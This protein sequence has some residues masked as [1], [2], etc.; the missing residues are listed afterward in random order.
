MVTFGH[1]VNYDISDSC[2]KNGECFKTFFEPDSTSGTPLQSFL[3]FYLLVIYL[4]QTHHF[5]Y[6]KLGSV[7]VMFGVF[8]VLRITV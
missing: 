6:F 3:G 4:L 8:I 7:F 5:F 2:G 1:S